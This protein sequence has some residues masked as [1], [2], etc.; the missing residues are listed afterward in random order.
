MPFSILV[1]WVFV[2]IGQVGHISENPFEHRMNDVPMSA[3]CRALEIDLRQ[4][5]GETAVLTPLQAE[6]GILY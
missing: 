1:Y 4:M 2:T 6:Q 3:L 5:L